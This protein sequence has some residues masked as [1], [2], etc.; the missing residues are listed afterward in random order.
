MNYVLSVF[1]R[2]LTDPAEL[3]VDCIERRFAAKQ[4]QDSRLNNVRELVKSRNLDAAADI[5][6]QKA[7]T[8]TDRLASDFLAS[9][10]DIFLSRPKESVA[11][12]RRIC[13]AE[14][15]NLNALFALGLYCERAGLA[16]EAI[17]HYK[18]CVKLRNFAVPPHQRIAA[19]ELSKG[20]LCRAIEEYNQLRS[21]FADDII[22]NLTLG[23]L[24]LGTDQTKA[25]EGCFDTAILLPDQLSEALE[26]PSEEDFSDWSEA[27]DFLKENPHCTDVEL[28]LAEYISKNQPY[29]NPLPYYESV[30]EKCPFSVTAQLCLA[31]HY[32]RNC[33]Y[34]EAAWFVQQA[35]L[36]MDSLIDAYVGMAFCG[37]IKGNQVLTAAHLE[38]ASAIYTSSLSLLS[39][40]FS[41]IETAKKSDQSCYFTDTQ[42][43]NH[44]AGSFD[45]TTSLDLVLL[46]KVRRESVDFENDASTCN[47]RWI[48]N[49][50]QSCKKSGS[51]EWLELPPLVEGKSF[52]TYYHTALLAADPIRF[53]FAVTNFT[54]K[55]RDGHFKSG[56]LDRLTVTLEE[57]SMVKREETSWGFISEITGLHDRIAWA[58]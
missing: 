12:L 30:I 25:A 44:P 28:R 31:G 16:N 2:G 35:R 50:Y 1:G 20:N 9:A 40:I 14:P 34:I 55:A 47:S 49:K 45:F 36:V 41:L 17:T 18:G 48:L 19:I 27:K 11:I 38:S 56:L 13:A 29:S 3:I 57:C 46:G 15:G 53:A 21:E 7:K 32:H 8:E 42:T 39:D 51:F 58:V 52:E 10:A 23:H 43:L 22:T 54:E 26:G 37:K 33:Q 4:R 5:L 24:F 6:R